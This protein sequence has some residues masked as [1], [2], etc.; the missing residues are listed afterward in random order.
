MPDETVRAAV[1]AAYGV[2]WEHEE[3]TD[4]AANITW[5][6]RGRA[7]DFALR[8]SNA[9]KTRESLEY[10]TRVL[11]YLAGRGF[12][13]P[14]IVLTRDG[15]P[16]LDAGGPLLMLTRFVVGAEPFDTRRPGLVAA[17][18]RLFG[19][20]HRLLR[21]MP[22]PHHRNPY[23]E[24]HERMGEIDADALRSHGA[25]LGACAARVLPAAEA[26]ALAGRFAY[27]GEQYLRVLREREAIERG[28]TWLPTHGSYGRGS[29]LCRGAE[30]AAVLDF[31][32][33]SYEPRGLDLAYAVKDFAREHEREEDK[34]FWVGFDAGV[35]S[36]FLREYAAEE[37]LPR[38][39]VDSLPVLWREQRA[40][41]AV[42]KAVNFL[43][44]M[45]RLD[46][47][48]LGVKVAKLARVIEQEAERL[49][50]VEAG[51]RCES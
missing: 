10:E 49:A 9:A 2:G 20:M 29:L 14:E 27:V 12:P 47:E 31:D 41:K 35:A 11:R 3:R 13:V 15:L 39:D 25:T 30:V 37:T 18:A 51:T 17:A 43:R 48:D 23:Y 33:S 16:Y 8:L 46:A 34:D 45:D 50:W 6:L 7:G 32:R 28:L 44:K 24:R 38:A 19:R 21:E 42:K 36:A 1:R 40:K 5:I 4:G 26:E 22:P